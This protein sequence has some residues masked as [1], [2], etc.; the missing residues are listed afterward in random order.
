MRLRWVSNVA[1]SEMNEAAAE[2]SVI[3][4]SRRLPAR[5]ASAAR[6]AFLLGLAG[7][8]G[9]A[10]QQHFASSSRE[11]FPESQYGRAS[12]R[13][14]AD[15][16]P[17]PRGGGQYLV[18][19]PYTVAGRT[20]YPT[21]RPRSTEIGMA[22]Y[23]GSAFH[24]RRTANGEIYDMSSI[25]AA[26]PTMPLPSYA[27]VTN[28]TNN[29]SIIV[30]VN[31][32]GP[33][34]AGRVMDV[35]DRAAQLLDFKRVGT[36]HVRVDYIGPA[37]LDARDSDMLMASLRTDGS[38]AQLGQPGT[39]IASAAP[40]PPPAPPQVSTV[41]ATFSPPPPPPRTQ[42]AQ[43]PSRPD[44]IPDAVAL[45]P[46][47]SMPVHAPLPP[48]R[49]FDLGTIPGADIP[50]AAPHQHQATAIVPRATPQVI[51]LSA[52]GPY[53]PSAFVR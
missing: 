8:A 49:P 51:R 29:R 4:W 33:Y 52:R 27:R 30:R 38:P 6:C 36:A 44:P 25:S 42:V 5:L 9:R 16:R 45:K 53:E 17:I 2:T 35:S 39:M 12:E 47:A 15:G 21:E 3:G 19:H 11:Y 22:S 40:T 23:Y 31:D 32:R 14:I 41:L 46:T 50:L 20:Y 7:C 28:L 1:S 48:A 24:G 13:V 37:G 43:I 18:G 34:A 10:P 26:H